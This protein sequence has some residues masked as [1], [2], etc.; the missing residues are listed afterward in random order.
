MII[1]VTLERQT[2]SEAESS[3]RY[4]SFLMTGG[5]DY[6]LTTWQAGYSQRSGQS[7]DG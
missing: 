6:L 5:S 4:F 1:N 7:G 2:R 3:R